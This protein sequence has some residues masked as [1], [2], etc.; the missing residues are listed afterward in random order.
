[1]E[2]TQAC[3]MPE[4]RGSRVDIE[5]KQYPSWPLASALECSPVTKG[6]SF[7]SGDMACVSSAI[8][9][10]SFYHTLSCPH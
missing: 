7:L 10:G 2:N 6:A 8:W 1:M 3:E 9:R 5:P 4:N